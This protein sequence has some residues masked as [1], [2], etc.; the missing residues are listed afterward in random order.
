VAVELVGIEVLV[1]AGDVLVA[2]VDVGLV[3]ERLGRQQ[4]VRLV[5]AVVG[6]PEGVEADG[7]RVDAEEEQPEGEG[8]AQTSSV[9]SAW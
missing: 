7:G 8:A 5:P 2:N 9:T 1:G 6:V 4:V 3:E